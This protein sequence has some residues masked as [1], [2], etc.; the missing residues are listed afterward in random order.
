MMAA[1]LRPSPATSS[2]DP[3]RQT[4]DAVMEPGCE[5]IW[6]SMEP[7]A[8]RGGGFT[9]DDVSQA[10]NCTGGAAEI[11]LARLQRHGHA[12]QVGL[13]EGTGEKIYDLTWRP[14]PVVFDEI[15]RPSDD[16][17]RRTCLWRTVKMTGSFTAGQLAVIASTEEVPVTKKCAQRFIDRLEEAGYLMALAVPGRRSGDREWRLR[18]EM[19]TG[20]LPPRFCD[21]R[22]VYDVNRRAFTQGLAVV[23]EVKL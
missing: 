14:W 9:V 16:H 18:P 7:L 10:A 21:L 12:Q 23:R 17:A 19:N 5:E 8:K 11:Y 15:G 13:K 3:H 4:V 1:N 20:P 6:L 2:Y 22:L